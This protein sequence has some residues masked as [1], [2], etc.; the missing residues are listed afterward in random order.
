M[1]RK[2]F[3]RGEPRFQRQMSFISTSRKDT[4][5]MKI[6][7]FLETHEGWWCKSCIAQST[8][9]PHSK[10]VE[11]IVHRLG[12]AQGYYA[13]TFADC[14]GCGKHLNCIRFSNTSP[15]P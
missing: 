6:A 9:L 13:R 2:F 1:R 10:Y 15:K 14:V 7:A 11:L 3:R 8:C 5:T 4:V 12:Q